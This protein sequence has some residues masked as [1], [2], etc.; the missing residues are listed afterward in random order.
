MNTASSLQTPLV[1]TDR[2][3]TAEEYGQLEDDGRPTEL[4]RGRIVRLNVPN[5]FHGK[6]CSRIVRILGGFVDEHDLGH[7]LCNNAGVITQRGPDTVRGPDVSFDSYSRVAK[8]ATT[9]GYPA[10][11]PE[12]IFEVRSPSDRWPKILAKVS[13]YLEAGVLVVY[14]VDPGDK[15]VTM[16]DTDQPGRRLE[17]DDQ[18]TFPEPLTGLR[19]PVRRLFR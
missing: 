14:V 10:V 15:T 9:A 4:V 11:A 12:V 1:A 19:I 5:F 6:H 3:L 17:D 7:V 2:L 13:E 8:D 18:L 16:F